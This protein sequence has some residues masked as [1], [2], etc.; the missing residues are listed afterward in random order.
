MKVV[1]FCGG[2]G[3]RFWP[4]SRKST[5]KQFVPFI[6]DRSFYQM[7]YERYRKEFGPDEIFISTDEDYIHYIQEQTPEVPKNNI[8]AEPERKDILGACG[9][10]TAVVNKYFPGESLL[11]SWSKHL[12]ARESVFLNAIK[13]AGKYVDET[14]LIVSIDSKPSY[15]S[16]HNGWVKKG[17]KLET[18]DGFDILQLEKHI[19]KPEK[20]VAQKLYKDGGWLINT[21]YRIWK[22]DVMLGYYKKMQPEMYEGMNKI[23]DAWGTPKQQ[24]VLKREY[25]EFKKDSIEYGIF[26]K[27]PKDVRAGIAADMGWED[28]GISWELF[29]HSLITPKRTTIVEGG[30]DTKFIDAENNLVIGDKKKMVAVIGLSDIAVIDTKD[31]LLVCKLDQSQKVKDLYAELEHYYKNYTE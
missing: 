30:C 19:E 4:I 3:T 12:I 25:H 14:G 18:I 9:L 2:Y 27:L 28:V 11:I 13:A 5:P 8:I 23:I 21:G 29:Y 22:T 24:E 6:K 1:I 16:I 26:E 10:A 17:K 7:T 15:P 20:D 31:G